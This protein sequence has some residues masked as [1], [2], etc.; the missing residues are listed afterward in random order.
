MVGELG[1]EKESEARNGQP[2][3]ASFDQSPPEPPDIA[4]DCST[5]VSPDSASDDQV[6]R[7]TVADVADLLVP[8]LE[9]ATHALRKND[10][11]E[12]RTI[13]TAALEWMRR[14]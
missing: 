5:S 12:A 14:L 10:I 3:S 4:P 13:I 9:R 6:Q 1:F 2:D 11:D 8:A 7:S